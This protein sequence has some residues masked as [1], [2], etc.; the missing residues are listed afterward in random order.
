MPS[1]V[2]TTRLAEVAGAQG[3]AINPG[4]EWS[5]ASDASQ[6]MRLCF[7]YPNAA[8]IDE[9]VKRLAEICQKEFGLPSHIANQKEV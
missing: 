7:G 1:A 6:Y 5:S 8:T 2:D 9:G 3:V 4:V